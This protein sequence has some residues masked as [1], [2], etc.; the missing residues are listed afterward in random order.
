V[1]K[2]YKCHSTYSQL[3]HEVKTRCTM[4][5]L[6]NNAVYYLFKSLLVFWIVKECRPVDRHQS[7]RKILTPPLA[8]KI[9]TA[10][11][12]H[13]CLPANPYNVTTQKTNVDIFTCMYLKSHIP[14]Q[15]I[16]AYEDVIFL[17]CFFFSQENLSNS[18]FR[19]F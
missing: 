10:Y 9:E 8:L 12:T 17:T 15:E 6:E 13:W 3:K 7:F 14:F 16:P 18:V 5:V 2:H 19:T 11:L 4:S 1:Q